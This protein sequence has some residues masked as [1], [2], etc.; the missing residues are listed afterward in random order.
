MAS[1]PASRKLTA[2]EIALARG[3]FGPSIDYARVTINEGRFMPFQP[4]GTA[5]APEGNLYMYGCYSA[6]YAAGDLWAQGH[7]IHEMTHVWQFQNRVLH[8]IQ[9]AIELNLRHLFNYQAA[10]DYQVTPG[11]DFL[12]Y[13]MEQQASM[14]QDYFMLTRGVPEGYRGHCRNAGSNA[15]KTALLHQV[16]APL[17]AN[18]AYARRE[19]FPGRGPKR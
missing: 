5:M 1:R 13:N 4:R 18:P 19:H 10:Y 15:E 16:L 3:V 12:A 14:V 9:A 11:R 6:D 8:P 7:F 2:G 17:L